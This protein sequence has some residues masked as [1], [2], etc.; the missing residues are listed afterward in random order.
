MK[1]S[2]TEFN[3]GEWRDV[4]LEV[5]LPRGTDWAL[6]VEAIGFVWRGKFIAR[7][8]HSDEASLGC[9]HRAKAPGTWRWLLEVNVAGYWEAILLPDIASL[10][11][12]LQIVE[13][14]WRIDLHDHVVEEALS[15]LRKGFESW[16]GHRPDKTCRECK[17]R[18][19]RRQSTTSGG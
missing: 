9:I 15:I 19:T 13:P 12:A 6:V 16:H 8:N 1:L 7:R 3:R 17:P 10:F 14:Y 18:R 5:D 4:E 11:Q 2:L